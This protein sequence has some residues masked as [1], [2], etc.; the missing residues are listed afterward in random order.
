[1]NIYLQ[2]I[3]LFATGALVLFLLGD[4]GLIGYLIGAWLLTRRPMQDVQT[5]KRRNDAWT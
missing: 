3:V 4:A 1:M 2:I 5:D